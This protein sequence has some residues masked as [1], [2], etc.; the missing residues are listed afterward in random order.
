MLK[1][2][3]NEVGEDQ[4]EEGGGVGGG[5]VGVGAAVE[6]EEAG[7]EEQD[8][9]AGMVD[10]DI[11]EAYEENQSGACLNVDP[12]IDFVPSLPS[13]LPLPFLHNSHLL[14]NK[15]CS[16]LRVFAKTLRS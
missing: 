10:G 9:D 12:S 3:E 4:E 5:D 15:M 14:R 8:H 16:R 6:G 7:E 1:S 2:A 11:L 13:H